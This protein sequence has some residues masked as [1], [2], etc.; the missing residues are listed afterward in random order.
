MVVSGVPEPRADHLEAL[1]DLALD[2]AEAVAGLTDSRGRAVPLRIGLAC[3]PVVAGVVGS[4]RFFYDVWG[5]AVNVASRMESTVAVGR[6]QVPENVYR[7]LRGRFVFEERGDVEVKGKG[8][9]HTWYLVG[10]NNAQPER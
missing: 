4:Q 10:H 3:G 8:L 9:M 5:D 7:R 2:I 1:A 6:I